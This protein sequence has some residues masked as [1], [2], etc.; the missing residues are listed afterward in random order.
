M[1]A[2]P[3]FSIDIR[4]YGEDRGADRHDFAQ[5]VLPLS[6]TLLMDIA[7]RESGLDPSRMAFVD[8]GAP[9]SQTSDRP[10]R[11]LILDLAPAV[12]DPEIAERLT[13]APFVQLTPA[14]NKL[15]DYMGLLAGSGQISASTL[16]LW[17]PLLLDTLAQ[18]APR[19]PSRLAALLAGI[20]AEPGLAWTTATMAE[21]AGVS[22]SRLHTLFRSEFDTTPHAWLSDVRLKRVREWLARSDRSIAELAYRAGYADQSALTRA[23]RQ[24]TGLTPAAYRRQSRAAAQETTH[25]IP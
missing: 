2:H 19:P 9:H 23:M 8:T 25:K 14:A 10:N 3:H 11:S 16:R 12:L 22:V 15:V 1:P 21:R 4:S 5:L 20:E 24:A 7:G 18:V 17:V 13:R 6:G